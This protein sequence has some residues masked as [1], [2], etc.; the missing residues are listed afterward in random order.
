[1]PT[2]YDAFI[3]VVTSL[4]LGDSVDPSH[5]FHRLELV[6]AKTA[7]DMAGGTDID[8][9]SQREGDIVRTGSGAGGI[10]TLDAAEGSP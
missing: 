7:A 4:Q 8:V 1:M 9:T 6:P 3:P 10:W 2:I 5:D